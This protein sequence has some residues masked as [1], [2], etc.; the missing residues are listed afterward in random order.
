MPDWVG[1]LVWGLV[2]VYWVWLRPRPRPAWARGRL[3]T[4]V[5][6]VV[7]LSLLYLGAV[8]AAGMINRR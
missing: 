2:V 7:S 4:A 3:V 6:V 8:L 1:P 5:E